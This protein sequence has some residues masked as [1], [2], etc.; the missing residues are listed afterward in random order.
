MNS[1]EKLKGHGAGVAIVGG[2]VIGLAV[3][4]ELA[5]RDIRDITLIER[6]NLGTEASFAAAGM[7]A[8]QAEADSQDQ[9]FNLLCR[10]RDLYPSFAES[11]RDETGIDIELET[12][13]T[14][15]LAFSEHDQNELDARYDWQTQAGLPVEKLSNLEARTLEACIAPNVS[16]ALRFPLDIQVENRRLLAALSNSV[17]KLGV[18]VVTGTNV[19]SIQIDRD[20]VTGVQTSAG[21]VSTSTVVVAAGTWTSFIAANRPISIPKVEPV[22]GQMVC[23]TAIP[24][25]TRHVIYSPRGYLVPRKDGRLLSGSTSEAAGFAKAATAG[26]IESILSHANEISPSVSGLPIADLW[27]GLRPRTTDGLPVLGACDEIEGL[28]YATGH[29]RNGILLAPFTA[30]LTADAIERGPVAE[31][32][33]FSPN[34][35]SLINVS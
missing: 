24:Q 2:G 29:Y 15:Y 30:Q 8:P 13:G 20:R 1:D 4:R 3:A 31:L 11:L 21:L 10:S 25:L 33:P 32:A 19:E 28:I 16:G 34:R 18:R 5:R 22:R 6:G 14:L 17:E 35:F 26:G 7:I 9:F 27:A 23:L 12:T